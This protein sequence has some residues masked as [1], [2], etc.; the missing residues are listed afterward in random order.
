M[1]DF[2]ALFCHYTRLYKGPNL[3]E[4]NAEN[5]VKCLNLLGLEISFQGEENSLLPPP[6][7][8]QVLSYLSENKWCKQKNIMAV[9]LV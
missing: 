7:I 5:F 6:P 3:G 8:I 1:F 2:E 9:T 4:Q